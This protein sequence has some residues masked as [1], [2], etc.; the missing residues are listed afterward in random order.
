M[1]GSFGYAREHF[2]VSRAIARTAAV[3]GDPA[4]GTRARSS[5]PPARRA[6]IRC[7]TLPAKRPSIRPCSSPP[8]SRRAHEPRALSLVALLVAILASTVTPLN[9]GVLALAFAWG[10]GLYGG[11]SL[12]D[13]MAGFPV[14]LVSHAR[15]RDAALH[16]GAAE[17]H[18]DEGRRARAPPVPRQRRSRAGD[19][20]RAGLRAG[21]GRAGTHRDHGARRADGDDRGRPRA[22]SGVSH[23]HH[24]RPRRDVRFAVAG[25]ADRHHRGGHH[26]PHRAA[27][28]RV[29]HIR[30]QPRG[31]GARRVRRLLRSS[32]DGGCSGSSYAGSGHR[33]ADDAPLRSQ[34][35]DHARRHRGAAPGGAVLRRQR[36][37]GR[38]RRRRRPCRCCAPPITRTPSRRCR[39]V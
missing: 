27:G 21:V 26:D 37:H 25:R 1:A 11:I 5:S 19:V 13:V 23:G 15:R 18:A 4:E 33:R 22:N 31:A 20:L 30:E 32:A 34:Q 3:A 38:V 10:I 36:R 12:N 17:R 7:S 8:T 14:S 2:E 9:V 35:L 28:T 6:V 24:G 39:G 16:A 29:V